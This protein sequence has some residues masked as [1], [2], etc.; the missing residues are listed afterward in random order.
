MK[1]LIAVDLQKTCQG[2]QNLVIWANITATWYEDLLKL[3][4]M[5][6]IIIEL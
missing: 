5:S 1:F 2:N 6:V 4:I 3:M